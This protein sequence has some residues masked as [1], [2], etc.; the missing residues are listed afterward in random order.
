VTDAIA[1]VT[2][3]QATRIDEQT[4]ARFGVDA[5]VLMENAGRGI[6]ETML[7]SG[8]DLDRPIVF[9]AGP[10]HNGGDALVVARHA[11]NAGAHAVTVVTTRRELKPLTVL[12]WNALEALGVP[13]IIW[14]EDRERAQRAIADAASIVDGISGTGLAG[15]LRSP[16]DEL[17]FTINGSAGRVVAID[18]PSGARDG[19]G[20]DAAIID[21]DLTVVTGA[22]KTFLYSARVRPHAGTIADVDPGFPPALIREITGEATPMRVISSAPPIRGVVPDDYKTRR[23]R[24]LIVGGS[25][26]SPGAAI[27]AAESAL[28]A[29]AGMARLLSGRAASLAAIQ[30][31]PA[32]L[33]GEIPAADDDPGWS[34]PL[35]WCDAIVAGPGWVGATPGEVAALLARAAKRDI[36][37]V[38]DASALRTLPVHADQLNPDWARRHLILT[39]HPGEMNAILAAIAPEIDLESMPFRAIGAVRES[40]PG[41]VVLKGSV[42]MIASDRAYD[43]VDGREPALATAGSGDVLAG[44]IGA[45]AARGND[46]HTAASAG[47]MI[48]LAAGR[49]T[50]AEIGWYTASDLTRAIGRVRDGA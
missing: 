12:Q 42:T 50:Y 6:W 30:R 16:I 39:P 3:D 26:P 13:R 14:D 21:A 35:E 7:D 36:P 8:V 32:L 44:L 29:G 33:V 19:A 17:V 10:G 2:A 40:I 27:L 22:R 1:L 15:A 24:V 20:R 4:Q 38:L 49:R 45:L 43:V 41:T 11:A 18:V 46:A 9:V 28:R 48:H 37:V 23:G 5:R 25:D 34:G 31:E 47:V